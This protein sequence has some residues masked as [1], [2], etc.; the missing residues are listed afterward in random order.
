MTTNR[1]TAFGHHGLGVIPSNPIQS[2][3]FV[4]HFKTTQ[5]TRV[6]YTIDKRQVKKAQIK[7]KKKKK[8][9]ITYLVDSLLKET[10]KNMQ[11]KYKCKYFLLQSPHSRF[12]SGTLLKLL[13]CGKEQLT[14]IKLPSY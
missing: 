6:L 9:S 11:V 12:P 13:H 1:S 2:N 10:N 14:S 7:H 5:L 3:L 8:A 4:Q